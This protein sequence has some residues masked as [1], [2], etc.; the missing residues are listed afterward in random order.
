MRVS[1]R[2]HVKFHGMGETD[3]GGGL[4]EEPVYV[5]DG[6]TYVSDSAL[7]NLETVL[8]AMTLQAGMPSTTFQATALPIP[9]TPSAL[10]ALTNWVNQGYVTLTQKNSPTNFIITKSP[11][12]IASFAG[13]NGTHAILHGPPVLLQLAT[14]ASE[15]PLTSSWVV[16][17]LVT[18][19]IVGALIWF[20]R[21]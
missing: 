21:K 1:P 5:S 2:R 8:Q 18:T 10:D 19:G 13:V 11:S 4:L 17:V 15:A 16:P 7:K 6:L 14:L 9:G 12:D 20:F 3:P